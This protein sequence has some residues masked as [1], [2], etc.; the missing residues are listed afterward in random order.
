MLKRKEQIRE[1]KR[2]EKL[3]QYEER[4]ALQEK[5]ILKSREKAEILK[6]EQEGIQVFNEYDDML[7]S[8][9]CHIRVISSCTCL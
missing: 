6:A 4:K 5:I 8:L 9:F 1:A 7:C 3:R 2:Q